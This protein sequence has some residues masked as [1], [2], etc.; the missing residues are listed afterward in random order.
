MKT[1]VERPSWLVPLRG[2][3]ESAMEQVN[4]IGGIIFAAGETDI[5]D[6]NS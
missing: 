3:A 5:D 6:P 4:V 2:L 1:N